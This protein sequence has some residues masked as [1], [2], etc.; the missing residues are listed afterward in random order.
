MIAHEFE[1][2]DDVL[3]LTF[4]GWLFEG[5]DDAKTALM[6][7]I[8][9]EIISRRLVDTKVTEGAKRLGWKLLKQVDVMRV[10]GFAGRT[11]MAGLT[12]GIP[13]ALLER[14]Q[15]CCLRD[16]WRVRETERH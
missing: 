6:G 13:G 4:N 2:K 1:G 8:L 14:W 11:A 12:G 10:M 15:G 3:L 7:T 16:Q 5:F 9:D